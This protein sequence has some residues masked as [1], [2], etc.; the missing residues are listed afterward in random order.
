M[1][2]GATTSTAHASDL[3]EHEGKFFSILHTTPRTQ[4][5]TMTIAAGT[6]AGPIEHHVGADQVFHVISGTGHFKVWPDGDKHGEHEPVI[7]ATYG[8]GAV[9]VV[10]A[11][12]AHWVAA[13]DDGPLFFLTVYGPPAY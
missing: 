4:T 2:R 3:A 8:P 9:L 10:P 7:D 1:A 11:D 13:T 12:T 6:E 5:A